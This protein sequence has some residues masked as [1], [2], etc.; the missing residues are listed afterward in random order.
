[1]IANKLLTG[2]LMGLIILVA[3]LMLVDQANAKEPTVV[4]SYSADRSLPAP[5]EAARV[6]KDF[7]ISLPK[8]LSTSTRLSW[9]PVSDL[10]NEITD[11]YT[12]H[13]SGKRGSGFK[14]IGPD[15]PHNPTKFVVL[16]SDSKNRV[17]VVY[18]ESQ[19]E[20]FSNRKTCFKVRSF[21]VVG[22]SA[23]SDI[24][25]K[26]LGTVANVEFYLDDD[27][28]SNPPYSSS[29]KAPYDF[30]GTASNGNALPFSVAALTNGN[31]S[32]IV[33][34]NFTENVPSKR[35]EVAFSIAKKLGTPQ[36]VTVT[37]EVQW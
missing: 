18:V 19:M 26:V 21:N 35:L 12:V 32:L 17:S 14:K 22:A 25:C 7:Y 33:I 13:Q 4:L 3:L 6:N 28:L 34:V 31:H 16:P 8:A 30:N 24:V 15:V 36:G 10:A 29:T 2:L 1:M 20:L 23:F 9:Y 11:G 37:Q 27:T 5:L